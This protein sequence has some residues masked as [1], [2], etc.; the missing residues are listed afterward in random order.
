MSAISTWF[1]AKE[2]N[3]HHR[4]FPVRQIYVWIIT[5][6][7][8]VV[9]VG[10]NDKFQFPGGK[11]EKGESRI[12][13]IERELY[14]ECGIKLQTFHTKPEFFGY[15]LVEND[16]NPIWNGETYLQLRYL[17]KLDEIS[18]GIILSVNERQDDFDKMSEAKFVS[19]VSLP[20]YIPWTKDLN[21]YKLVRELSS[22]NLKASEF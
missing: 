18:E 11:P 6:D 15:Y 2:V 7:S 13:T 10:N 1:T 9:I 14:E 17:L 21:E 22:I 19:L 20:Q 4:L 5:R 3:S 16:S 8:K 12:Q